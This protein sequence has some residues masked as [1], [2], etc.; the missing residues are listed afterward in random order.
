MNNGGF[1]ISGASLE[2]KR[3]HSCIWFQGFIGLSSGDSKT[4]ALHY[5]A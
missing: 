3:K 1:C 5:D 2:K 4:D